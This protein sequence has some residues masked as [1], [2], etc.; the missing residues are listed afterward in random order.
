MDKRKKRNKMVKP[1]SGRSSDGDR[2]ESGLLHAANFAGGERKRSIV[3]IE[4]GEGGKREK[5][6]MRKDMR[7]RNESNW[8]CS[9]LYSY[10][11]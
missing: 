7:K 11:C 2:P 6:R 8:W 10:E 3:K 5:E 9:N 1:P 4:R